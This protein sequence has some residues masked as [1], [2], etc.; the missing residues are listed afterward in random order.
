MT[1][2][3]EMAGRSPAYV[4]KSSDG[5]VIGAVESVVLDSSGKPVNPD[6][7]AQVLTYNADGTLATVAFTDGTNTWTKTMGYTS[8]NLTSVSA[9]VKA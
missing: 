8:G 1:I 3:A 9:W 6:N 4:E 5:A 2:A 7:F